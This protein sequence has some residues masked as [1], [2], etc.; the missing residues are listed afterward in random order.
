MH[1]GDTVHAEAPVVGSWEVECRRCRDDSLLRSMAP[2][3]DW[4]L[5]VG[6]ERWRL[7]ICC[8]STSKRTRTNAAALPLNAVTHRQPAT[9]TVPRAG[10]I[11]GV[12][13]AGTCDPSESS[14]I[15]KHTGT[16]C[17]NQQ[18][19]HPDLSLCAPCR[20]S[21]RSPDYKDEIDVC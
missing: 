13:V 4:L 8:G 10:F 19:R 14:C 11:L 18:L 21:R 2:T 6:L 17:H 3:I 15:E 7:D 20:E 16:N 9:G 5:Q 1:F 12:M